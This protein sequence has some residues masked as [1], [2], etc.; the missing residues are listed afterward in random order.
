MP[1]IMRNARSTE[2]GKPLGTITVQRRPIPTSTGNVSGEAKAIC[3]NEPVWVAG[4]TLP[5]DLDRG[6]AA[7]VQWV[8]RAVASPKSVGW[9]RPATHFVR[10]E[11]AHLVAT[12]GWRLH[13]TAPAFPVAETTLFQVKY[14]K[15]IAPGRNELPIYEGD[16]YPGWQV[17]VPRRFGMEIEI[18]AGPL[19]ALAKQG[20]RI[21]FA[22]DGLA[23]AMH[24]GHL[25]DAIFGL[26]KQQRV[27]ICLN[28]PGQPIGVKMSDRGAVLMPTGV[29]KIGARDIF[30]P[31][32]LHHAPGK[33]SPQHPCTSAQNIS[34][35]YAVC[36][37][38]AM[39][40]SHAAIRFTHSFA[41]PSQLYWL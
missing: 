12:D 37:D 11:P 13:F 41:R 9:S 18:D 7:R 26:G 4:S 16:D 19:Q 22:V 5:V 31:D 36:W 38:S 10:A 40:A 29:I 28:M 32:A 27:Q 35:I 15:D 34:S 14:R 24:A 8:A 1:W 20:D 2:T 33:D 25:T 21:A 17:I 39:P 30:T 3:S 6:S 23:F